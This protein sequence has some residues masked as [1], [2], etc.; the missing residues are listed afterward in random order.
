VVLLL[1]K[2]PRGT[3]PVPGG[4]RKHPSVYRTISKYNR[5]KR[6]VFYGHTNFD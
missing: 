5:E 4:R 2:E 6:Q 1:T 3:A